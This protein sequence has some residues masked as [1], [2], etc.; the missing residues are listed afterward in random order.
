MSLQFKPTAPYPP[1]PAAPLCF[2][3]QKPISTIIFFNATIS[4]FSFASKQ[5]FEKF[6]SFSRPV[7]KNT[8]AQVGVKGKV[9][10]FV[11]LQKNLTCFRKNL[12]CTHTKNSC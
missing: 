7:F 11:S 9:I 2:E 12:F 3:T 10:G 6:K 4:S 1:L 5:I 8:D